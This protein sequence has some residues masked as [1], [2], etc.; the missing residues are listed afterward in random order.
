[1][2][3]GMRKRS[4]SS[5]DRRLLGQRHVLAAHRHRH[6][7]GDQRP[8]Q[9]GQGRRVERTSTAIRD[10]GRP[11]E[12]RAPQHPGDVGGLFGGGAQ[13]RRPQH[14]AGVGSP[15]RGEIARC[16]APGPGS[17]AATRRVAASS[18]AR[19]G[20]TSAASPRARHAHRRSG[21][22]VSRTADASAPRKA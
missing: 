22:G 17:R 10:H 3:Y 15:G 14:C 1:M 16:S 6:P 7:G 12:V 2:Q 13:Q 5:G 19:S 20:G 18:G 8:A 9:H 4:S 21:L 11:V